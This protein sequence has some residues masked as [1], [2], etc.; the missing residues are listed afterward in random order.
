ME[1]ILSTAM[2]NSSGSTDGKRPADF[3]RCC[4][5]KGPTLVLIKSGEYIFGGYTSKSWE[6]ADKF[7]A[8]DHSFLFTLISPSGT[9][10]IR[11]SAE[12]SADRNNG[13]ILC[14]TRLGP[15]FGSKSYFKLK[16]SNAVEGYNY[17]PATNTGFICPPNVTR[18]FTPEQDFNIRELEIFKVN[19]ES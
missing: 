11:L 6:S 12:P 17:L 14:R 19:F 2:V 10:P 15:C 3:H 18:A 9:Q 1:H 8:D 4:D 16:V 7:K 13:G 5:N